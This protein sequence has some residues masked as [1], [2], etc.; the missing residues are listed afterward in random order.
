MKLPSLGHRPCRDLAWRL[1][2]AGA[3][4]FLAACATVGPDYHQPPE[5]IASQPAAGA[6][7]A[8][9]VEAPYSDEPLPIRW[10]RL[11]RDPA[12][13]RLVEQALVH[14]TDLRQATANLERERAIEAGV[15]SRQRPTLQLSAA[16]A[17]GHVSGVSELQ[18]GYVPPNT[19]QYATDA[20]LSYELDL[21]GQLRR[22][23]E[24]AHATGEATQ[25]ALDLVRINVAAG[26]AAAYADVCSTGLRL[27]SAE[28]SVRL[29]QD[30]LDISERLERAGR[31]SVLDTTRSRAQLEQLNAA[32][33]P[34]KARRQAALYRLAT[35]TGALPQDFPL[36]VASCATP[37]RVT[38][39]LPTGDGAALLRRRPDIRQAERNLAAATADIG[40]ATADLYPH[41]RLGLA[42]RSAS[43]ASDFGGRD[44]LSWSAGP[45]IS[46]TLP[47]TGAVQ[48]RI[49]Q[50]EAS[51]RGALARFDGTVLTAL[52]ETETALSAYAR[53]LDRHAALQ[54]AREQSAIAADQAQKL[55]QNGRTAALDALEAQR[56]LAGNEAALA[57]SDAELANDQVVLF[58]AL[59]GGWETGTEAVT[60]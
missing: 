54:E 48:A 6:S 34:L 13:D 35:L 51:T 38:G 39:L 22:A 25:A 47:N 53:E 55:Y 28:K 8:G 33:P 52:R 21:F 60:R 19:W 42:G 58:L 10:W 30:A 44:S 3:T 7:F 24:S 14:N 5:A 17:F 45:L 31:A 12:L 11:F 18:R 1:G 56:V 37:P 49:A 2:L 23:I 32:V 50:A 4:A 9:S 20:S 16:P 41:V 40:V 36:E 27:R 29:Q 59:G 46:W 43:L 15:D 26:T 57:A